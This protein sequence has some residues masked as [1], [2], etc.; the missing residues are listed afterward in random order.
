MNMWTI[1]F[2]K[3]CRLFLQVYLDFVHTISGVQATD[4][5]QSSSNIQ[6]RGVPGQIQTLLLLSVRQY[7]PGD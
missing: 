1:H 4:T 3:L 7:T 5:L 6:S 2:L